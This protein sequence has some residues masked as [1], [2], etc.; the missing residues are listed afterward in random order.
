MF[1]IAAIVLITIIDQQD[2]NKMHPSIYLFIIV[3]ALFLD[4]TQG[5]TMFQEND[6][7]ILPKHMR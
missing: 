1:T 5:S 7:D 2:S 4:A 6:G 3:A